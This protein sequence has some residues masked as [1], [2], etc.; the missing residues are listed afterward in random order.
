MAAWDNDCDIVFLATPNS[1][2]RPVDSQI[3]LEK[4]ARAA[5]TRKSFVVIDEAFI[6]FVEEESVKTDWCSKI[7]I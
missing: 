7:P 6:D 5:L 3:D 2:D 1:A 4:I